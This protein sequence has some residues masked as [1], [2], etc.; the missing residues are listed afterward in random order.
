[1]GGIQIHDPNFD[2]KIHTQVLDHW[3]RLAKEMIQI[4]SFTT[5]NNTRQAIK[6]FKF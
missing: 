4:H 2:Q 1:M 5:K 3:I 6:S